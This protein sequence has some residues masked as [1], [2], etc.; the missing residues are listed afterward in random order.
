[1]KSARELIFS[2]WIEAFRQLRIQG[3]LNETECKSIW[4]KIVKLINMNGYNLKSV[5]SYDYEFERIQ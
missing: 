4:K 2:D 5:G 1:M 3:L